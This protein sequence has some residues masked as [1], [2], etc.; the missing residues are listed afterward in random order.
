M[1]K[2]DVLV[3]CGYDGDHIV[4]RRG[5]VEARKM[6]HQQS[7]RSKAETFANQKQKERRRDDARVNNCK[8]VCW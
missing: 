2:V 1:E 5:R 6:A 3:C 7:G 8:R 4:Q